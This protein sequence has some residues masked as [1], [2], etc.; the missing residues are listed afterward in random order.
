[1]APGGGALAAADLRAFERGTG[2][3]RAREEAAAVAEDDL[4][5]GADVDQQRHRIR[6]IG[7]LGQHHARGIRADVPG[8]A[9]QH[10]D[11]CVPVNGEVDLGRPEGQRGIGR[12][13]ERRAA[14]LQR[15][16]AE[17]QVV[18]D[19]VADERRLEDVLARDARLPRDVRG[20][21]VDRAAHDVGQLLFAAGIHHHPG[22]AAHQVFAEPDLR[23]HRP[24]GRHDLAARQV[25]KMRGD[26]RRA[27]VDRDAVDPLAKARP[28]GDDLAAAV[29]GDRHL[30]AALAQRGLQLLQHA[31]VAG[32]A[33]QPPLEVERIL[34]PAQVAGRIVHVGLLHLDV[35]QAHDRIELDVVRFGGFAHHLPVHLAVGR[36]VD[37]EVAQHERRA[38]Q[39]ASG[40][41]RLVAAVFLLDGAER[42][43]VGR[44]ARSRRASRNSLRPAATWQRP[45]RPRPPQTGIDVHAE[46]ARAPAGAACRS[47]RDRAGPTA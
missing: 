21:I 6:Q 28:H 2:G 19:R 39:P 12:E 25:A 27:H 26:R 1:M 36:H 35:V 31:D 46:R 14:Q 15:T 29:H 32:E 7:P 9:R 23:I 42:R 5:V 13:R 16:D 17:Q 30:P 37:D 33:G 43:Q 24:G 40:R 11:A 41:H 4:G 8:D 3:T 44:R 22:H 38:R 20:E 18:H 45:H 34:Q 47:A 10:V